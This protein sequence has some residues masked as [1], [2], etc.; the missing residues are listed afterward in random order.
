MTDGSSDVA[1]RP[2][3]TWLLRTNGVSIA[4][5]STWA[6]L[7]RFPFEQKLSLPRKIQYSLEYY[8]CDLLLVHRDA[9][10]ESRE[11]RVAEIHAAIQEIHLPT[12]QLPII[13][14]IPV[15]MQE[16]WLLFD[17]AAIRWAAGNFHGRYALNLPKIRELEN[18]PNP[19]E[20]LYQ[21]LRQASGLQGRRL[22]SFPVQQRV[23]R[24]VEYIDDFSPLRTLPAFLALEQ[25]VQEVVTQHLTY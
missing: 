18:I 24:V 22:K 7:R 23:H 15:R 10:R 16:A 1:L 21:L 2:I 8:P 12:H 5:Q 6:D 25:D 4:I 20:L 17:E 14:V 3:L 19:K 13:C 9:E 11:K